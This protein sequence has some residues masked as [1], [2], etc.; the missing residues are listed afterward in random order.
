MYTPFTSRHFTTHV[1][2]GSGVRY[3]VLTTRVAPVQQGFYFVNNSWSND[4]RYLWFYC[5]FPPAAGHSLGVVDFLTDEVH[6]FPETAAGG[7]T[8]LVDPR[9]G[10]IFWGTGRGVYT[11]TPHPQDQPR[12]VAQLPPEII[13]LGVRNIGTH[14]TFTPDY[15]EVLADVQTSCGS[16]IGTFHLEKGDFTLWYHTPAGVPYNHAQLNPADG[17]VCMCAHEHHFDPQEGKLMPPALVDGVYPRLQIIRRDGTRRMIPPYNNSATHEWWAP[18]GR[19]IYYCTHEDPDTGIVAQ[20]MLDGS[21]SRVV[22]RV[23]VPG[24]NGTWHAHCTAD[25]QFFVIDG[26]H[27]CMGLS[28]WRGCESMVHFFHRGSGK[29]LRFITRNPMVGGWTPENP[30]PY[31]IDP[32]PRF[33]LRDTMIVF[34]TTMM[35]KVDLAVTEVAP[36]VE[37]TK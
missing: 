28:W 5:A 35:G 1:D 26:S 12:L 2:P 19:S 7:E 18:D 21:P 25:E 6:H 29:L 33:T 10:N 22:A 24:G 8:W 36:L 3:A 27:H 16:Y 9:T 4:G 14:L 17:D 11:R 30:C 20:D 13:R 32:H 31:H 34:T 15:K 23:P 37:R